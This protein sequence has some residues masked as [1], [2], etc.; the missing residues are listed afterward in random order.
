MAGVAAIAVLAS[1]C[2]D[3]PMSD[4]EAAPAAADAPPPTDAGGS[5]ATIELLDFTAPLVGGGTFDGATYGERP[6]VLWFWAPT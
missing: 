3:G 1:A 6:V 5:G 2:G 4:A